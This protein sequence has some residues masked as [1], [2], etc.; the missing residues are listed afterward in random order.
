MDRQELLL[1]L[2][3]S[4]IVL[5]QVFAPLTSIASSDRCSRPD[6]VAGTCSNPPHIEIGAGGVDLGATVVIPGSGGTRGGG[7]AGTGT[8]SGTGTGPGTGTGTGSATGTGGTGAPTTPCVTTFTNTCVTITPI[9]QPATG[10]AALA[11]HGPIVLSDLVNFMPVAGTQRMEPDGWSIVHLDTNF[12]VDTTAQVQDGV[13]L[14]A[15]ASVRFTPTSFHW[16]YGDGTTTTLATRGGS[17]TATGVEEFDSTD[18]SHVFTTTGSYRI[19]LTIE[20]RAEYRYSGGDWT[21]IAGTVPV[22]TNAIEAIV[23][24]AATVLVG[25]ECTTDPTSPGC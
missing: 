2:A 25:E 20:F 23:E 11:E 9:G 10:Q 14:G 21:A 15:P 8:G 6:I 4:A 16:D 18:T 24:D 22:T 19:S 17:W 1:A 13:L 12:F 7:G 5:T 3:S